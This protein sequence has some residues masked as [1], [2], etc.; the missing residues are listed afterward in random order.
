MAFFRKKTPTSQASFG[1]AA[2]KS[3][4]RRSGNTPAEAPTSSGQRP[5]SSSRRPGSPR[6][7]AS[8][9]SLANVLIRP[10]VTEKGTIISAHRAYAFNVA[11]WANKHEIAAAVRATYKVTPCKVTVAR[12]P[13]KERFVRGKWGTK[14]GGK[15]AYVFLKEGEKIE[16]V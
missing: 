11:K 6:V 16:F 15:K 9:R 8:H 2:P 12:I 14:V 4:P 13:S 5:T 10:R 3:A 7:L 1:T